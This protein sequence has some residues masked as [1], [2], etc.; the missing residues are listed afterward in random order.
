M[1]CDLAAKFFFYQFFCC[2]I[3]SEIFSI[4]QRIS[5]Q[6][7]ENH[8]PNSKT[9]MPGAMIKYFNMVVY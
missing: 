7:S 8:S 2:C 9:T 5:K 1:T 6:L 4:Y 3:G